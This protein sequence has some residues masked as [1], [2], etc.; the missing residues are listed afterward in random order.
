MNGAR[1]H[2]QF[3][4]LHN[5][6]GHEADGD[7]PL[8]GP[9]PNGDFLY[10]TTF[11]GGTPNNYVGL[12]TIYRFNRDGTGYEIIHHFA[13]GDNDGQAPEGPVTVADSMLYGMTRHGGSANSGTVYKVSA[14]GDEFQLLHQFVGPPTEGYWPNA[15]VTVVND[16]VYGMTRLGGAN[17]LGTIFQ[18]S[19]NGD[20]YQVLRSFTGAADDGSSP[21]GSLVSLGTMLYGMTGAGGSNN[22]GTIFQIGTDGGEFRVLH[23]FSGTPG[24]G[25]S[26][27]GDLTPVDGVLYGLTPG[28]GSDGIGTIFK[29]NPDGSGYQVLHSFPGGASY[30]GRP[31]GSLTGVGTNL[32]G[33]ISDAGTVSWR[34]GVIYQTDTNATT[35]QGLYGFTSG[36]NDARIPAGTLA[37][38]GSTLYG[39][40]FY[41]GGAYHSGTLFS[42]VLAPT[43]TSSNPLPA[44]SLN[45]PYSYTF[46]ATGDA[47]PFGWSYVSG[48]LPDG[49]VFANGTLS[50]RPLNETNVQF[51]VRANNG[52]QE[53]SER[54]FNLT[55]GPSLYAPLRLTQLRLQFEFTR[56]SADRFQVKG[57]LGTNA[58]VGFTGKLVALNVSGAEVSFVLDD[59]GRGISPLGTCRVRKDRATGGCQVAATLRSGNW[60]EAWL[61]EIHRVHENR[62]SPAVPARFWVQLTADGSEFFGATTLQ[63]W[64]SKATGYAE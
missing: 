26:P 36:L 48:D 60:H 18:V 15:G 35:V 8:S 24:D 49:L 17:S 55:I 6:A 31:T 2:A 42:F 38:S 45:V 63:Y 64:S 13:G 39:V 22:L 12:G 57:T 14:T 28:G 29:I 21:N 59:K 33:T 3:S 51:R 56:A 43:I 53:S 44:G 61:N 34:S 9:V 19:T 46:S 23:S 25:S 27:P 40:T 10:G 41:G 16:T 11:T 32:F 7:F 1:A 47:G 5:F 62:S 52:F 50:G 20:G 37:V 54:D 4:G 30:G 58:C